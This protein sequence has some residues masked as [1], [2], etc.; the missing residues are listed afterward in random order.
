MN[1]AKT[2]VMRISRQPSTVQILIGQKQ[3][4]SLEYFNCLCS[5]ITN[6]ARCTREIKC[7]IVMATAACNSKNVFTIK[8]ELS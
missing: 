5:V 3:L 4:E 1:V 8:L 2:K 6:N 7:R